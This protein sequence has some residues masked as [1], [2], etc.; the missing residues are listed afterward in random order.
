MKKKIVILLRDSN[1]D[2]NRET[3]KI[4]S[5]ITENHLSANMRAVEESRLVLGAE[6]SGHSTKK[7]SP[8]SLWNHKNMRGVLAQYIP[9]KKDDYRVKD[10]L[11]I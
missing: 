6:W 8:V 10:T 1:G 4:C 9:F 7:C 11:S 3:D 2:P 5:L